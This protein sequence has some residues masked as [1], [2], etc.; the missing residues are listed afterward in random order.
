MSDSY[1]EYRHARQAEH[2]RIVGID[3]ACVVAASG[4]HNLLMIGS[5]G[6]G[7]SMPAQRLPNLYALANNDVFGSVWLYPGPAV[8]D[9]MTVE[10][11]LVILHH[12][13]FPG[14]CDAFTEYRLVRAVRR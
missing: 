1:P 12:K 13:A 3:A 4:G 5:P 7:E 8:D 10:A 14:V 9:E 2:V 11:K 6:A